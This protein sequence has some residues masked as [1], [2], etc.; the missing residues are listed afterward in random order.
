MGQGLPWIALDSNLAANPKIL[1]LVAAR[2]HKA[3]TAYCFGLGYSGRLGLSGFVPSIALPLI[4][5]TKS[6][7]QS[8]V[9][10]GLWIPSGQGGWDINDW[11]DW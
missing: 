5:A 2:K 7:A 11:G 1:A 3:I 4:H 9:E 10:V 6:D 8:L